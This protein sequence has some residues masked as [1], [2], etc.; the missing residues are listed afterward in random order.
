MFNRFVLIY[1]LSPSTT[2]Y[3]ILSFKHSTLD[4]FYQAHIAAAYHAVHGSP[5]QI[6]GIFHSLNRF[7]TFYTEHHVLLHLPSGANTTS[8]PL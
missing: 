6:D 7:N 4:M 2:C 3:T 5:N 8:G 1:Y